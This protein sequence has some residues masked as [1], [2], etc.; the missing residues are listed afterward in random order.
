M[1]VTEMKYDNLSS[2]EEELRELIEKN[3]EIEID[4]ISAGDLSS[5]IAFFLPSLYR[6]LT[7]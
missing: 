3:A 2:I 4:S 6:R 5:A 7:A 1:A